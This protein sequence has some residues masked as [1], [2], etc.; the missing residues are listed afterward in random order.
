[1]SFHDNLW[2]IWQVGTTT[3][4]KTKVQGQQYQ[5]L[6]YWLVACVRVCMQCV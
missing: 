1:M 5:L 2:H 3:A 4:T 6:G